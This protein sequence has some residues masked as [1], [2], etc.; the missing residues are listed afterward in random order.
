[1]KRHTAVAQFL[2]SNKRKITAKDIAEADT[3]AICLGEYE[4]STDALVVQLTC[5]EK[6]VFHHNCLKEWAKTDGP[7]PT[8]SKF[9]AR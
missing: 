2:E 5:S 1:V 8:H 9:Y 3:C 4:E 6:H 7:L